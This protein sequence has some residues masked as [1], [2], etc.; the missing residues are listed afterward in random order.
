M[1]DTMKKCVL[2]VLLTVCLVASIFAQ[3]GTTQAVR[4]PGAGIEQN[5]FL[6]TNLANLRWLSEVSTGPDGWWVNASTLIHVRQVADIDAS[7]TINWND[8]KGFKPIGHWVAYD[9]PDYIGGP[10]FGNWFLGV[11]DGGEFSITNLY[12][13]RTPGSSEVDDWDGYQA[14]FFGRIH[15]ST[16]KNVRLINN[17]FVF[18]SSYYNNIGGIVGEAFRS[19][20]ENCIVTGNVTVHNGAWQQVG[21]IIG[22]SFI[23][24]INNCQMQG[25]LNSISVEGNIGGIVGAVENTNN[26][27]AGIEGCSVTGNISVEGDYLYVGGIAGYFLCYGTSAN[28]RAIR[29]S[30]TTGDITVTGDYLVVGGIAGAYE[31]SAVMEYIFTRGNITVVGQDQAHVGGIIGAN[32]N[33]P[34]NIAYSSGDIFGSSNNNTQVGGIVGYRSQ[35]TAPTTNA[36]S[37]GKITGVSNS[38]T[39][40]VGGIHG[41]HGVTGTGN[42]QQFLYATG[43]ITSSI[44]SGGLIGTLANNAGIVSYSY[45][46]TETTGVSVAWGATGATVNQSNV[47]GR[48]TAAMKVQSNYPTWDFTTIWAIDPDINNGYPHLRALRYDFN[49]NDDPDPIFDPPTNLTAVLEGTVVSLGWE[50]TSTTSRVLSGFKVFRNNSEIA[51]E[52]TQTFYTDQ[53]VINNTAYTYYVTAVYE[54]PTGESEPSDTAELHT[55][56]PPR[57]LS[58]ELEGLNVILNW[59][60]PTGSG[61]NGY[62]VYRDN[63]LQTNTA[64]NA[65]TWTDSNTEADTEYLYEITAL[66]TTGESIRLPITLI[67]P[68]IIVEF[69]PPRLLTATIEDGFIHLTWHLPEPDPEFE[70]LDLHSFKVYRNGTLLTQNITQTQYFDNEVVNQTFYSYYVTAVYT[71]LGETVESIPSNLKEVTTRFPVRNLCAISIQH[72]V[73]LEWNAPI[74]GGASGYNVF[75]NGFLLNSNLLTELSFTDESTT[76]ASEYTYTVFAVYNGEDSPPMEISIIV[77]LLNP[78][79]ELTANTDIQG[80]VELSWQAPVEMLDFE[81][82]LGYKVYRAEF[83]LTENNLITET[84]ITDTDVHSGEYIYKVIAVYEQ[85]E[86]IPIEETV[87]VTVSDGEQT[88]FLVITDLV[89]NFPNP[90][91]PSTTIKFNLAE[92]GNVILEIY[93][94]RGQKVKSL[95]NGIIYKGKHQIVWNGT[96]DNGKKVSSGVY[97]CQ[98]RTK[99]L[100]SLKRMIL[101]K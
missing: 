45:W 62:N 54:N 67:T 95:L 23:T 34:V 46:D 61:I 63:V 19:L 4:P 41:R 64:L 43:E 52:L 10:I 1:E 11:Y 80:T 100:S 66:Y 86:S 8:G 89:G 3:A 31:Q 33:G 35:N 26:D 96:D 98:M 39:C 82:F 49:M 60:A 38:G 20:L 37:M 68:E 47:T 12:M 7:E 99:E 13:N 15:N 58:Y 88:D 2:T 48:T 40:S 27:N 55:K 36:H 30:Y 42:Y 85:G 59:L 78:A 14:G 92:T 56:F 50:F 70:N 75:R 6:I 51:S 21:G 17:N 28:M 101:M 84:N 77:P 44:T 24:P 25:N 57:A 72:T 32:T 73:K 94:I 65:L 83:N 5:P 76:P 71:Y 91:N 93:N 69:S 53:T 81:V 90:F 29:N 87:I 97:L 18:E 22:L 16:I 74:D 79:R 9:E